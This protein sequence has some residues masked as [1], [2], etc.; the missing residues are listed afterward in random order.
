MSALDAEKQNQAKHVVFPEIERVIEKWD[1]N[2]VP[3]LE[4]QLMN[5]P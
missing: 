5:E 1:N 4:A 2:S 3:F